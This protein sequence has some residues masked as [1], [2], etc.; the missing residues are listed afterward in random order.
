MVI[1]FDFKLGEVVYLKTDIEQF[2]RIVTEIAIGGNSM[3]D[4]VII[5][6]LSLEE[7]TSKHYG[8]EITKNKDAII[9][10]GI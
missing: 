10:L 5:Y 6:E 3:S 7:S 9:A 8:T 1:N 4:S 2:K